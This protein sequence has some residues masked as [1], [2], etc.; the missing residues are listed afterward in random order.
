MDSYGLSI[1]FQSL[2]G[3]CSFDSPGEGGLERNFVSYSSLGGGLF[4]T[5]EPTPSPPWGYIERLLRLNH[6]HG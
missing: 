6:N 5:V 3:I 4:S 2:T 1:G